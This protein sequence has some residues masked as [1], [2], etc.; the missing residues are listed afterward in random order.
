MIKMISKIMNI[1]NVLLLLCIAILIGMRMIS[2]EQYFILLM[3]AYVI[4]ILA[5]ESARNAVAARLLIRS[6][7]FGSSNEHYGVIYSKTIEQDVARISPEDFPYFIRDLY[8]K[9]GYRARV[10]NEE[11]ESYGIDVIAKKDEEILAIRAIQLKNKEDVVSN[12]EIQKL[13][14]GMQL[15]HATKA[16]VI[17]NKIYASDK[18]NEG[19][20]C[21]TE[22]AVEQARPNE[23]V[24][25][26]KKGLQDLVREVIF[27]T[28]RQCYKKEKNLWGVVS[29]CICFHAG[30]KRY[31]ILRK[32]H[33]A[34]DVERIDPFDFEYLVSDLLI[35]MGYRSRVTQKIDGGEQDR[36]GDVIAKRKKESII[37]QVK[38]RE[39]SE[40]EVNEKAVAEAVAAKAVYGTKH[41]MVVTNGL[42]TEKA[43]KLAAVNDTIMID[44]NK[45]RELI[46]KYLLSDEEKTTDAF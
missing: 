9:K 11:I 38:H 37:V 29:Q 2:L 22:A 21:F 18:N 28:Q 3:I 16:V 6:G 17:A 39:K 20:K 43:M 34:R 45:L 33:L 1:G 26:G 35:K 46:I 42:F 24:L 10:V 36:G 7:C 19:D 41:S 5:N 12:G 23:V 25:I 14:A 44:G 30:N 40:Y 15:Y 32:D 31:G 27:I 4:L 8:I 13:V